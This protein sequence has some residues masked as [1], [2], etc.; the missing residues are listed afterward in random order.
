MHPPLLCHTTNYHDLY[1]YALMGTAYCLPWPDKI[2][3][4]VSLDNAKE[5]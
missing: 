2:H 5:H 1:N 3:Y 4:T